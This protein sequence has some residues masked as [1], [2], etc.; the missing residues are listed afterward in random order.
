MCVLCVCGV[1]GVCVCVCVCVCVA[2]VLNESLVKVR[3]CVFVAFV[4]LPF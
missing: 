2:T 1:C 4:S 3:I